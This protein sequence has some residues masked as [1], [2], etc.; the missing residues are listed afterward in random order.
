MKRDIIFRGKVKHIGSYRGH[1]KDK[2]NGEWVFGDLE[3]HRI[4]ELVRIHCYKEDKTYY[5]QYDVDPYTVGQ[6]TGIKDKHGVDIYEGDI[7]RYYTIETSCINPDCDPFNYIY[8]CYVK[9]IEGIV[10]WDNGMFL[11]EDYTPLS[12][13]GLDNLEE[14]RKDLN[15]EKENDYYD[16]NGTKIDESVLGIEI[17][18]NVYDIED[19]DKR[20]R[21]QNY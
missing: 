13:A 7:V 21:R 19:Y 15:V 12:Y 18:G 14:L 6:F 2:A 3:Q 5:R 20:T 8:Q 11:A 17:V 16:Y 10:E 1:S 9:K 4:D